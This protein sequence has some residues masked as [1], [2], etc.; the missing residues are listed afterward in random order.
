MHSQL[1]YMIV[2][3]RTTE[4]QRASACARLARDMR[5]GKRSSGRPSRI[6]RLP[7]RLVCFTGQPP[8]TAP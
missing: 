4:L 6:A 5:A 3:Q 7:A 8:R 1:N 2:Q